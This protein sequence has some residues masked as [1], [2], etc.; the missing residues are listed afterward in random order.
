MESHC[1]TERKQVN[2]EAPNFQQVTGHS[3]QPFS[4]AERLDRGTGN[5]EV[6]SSVA[7]AAG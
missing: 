1:G 6:Y 7:E 4:Q 2:P 3:E 5:P